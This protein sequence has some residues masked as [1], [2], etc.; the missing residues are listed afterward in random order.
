MASYRQSDDLCWTFLQGLLAFFVNCMTNYIATMESRGKGSLYACYISHFRAAH[1]YILP[2]PPR[3]GW[4]VP[5][6][7]LSSGDPLRL[8]QKATVWTRRGHFSGPLCP[9][10]LLTLNIFPLP[11]CESQGQIALAFLTQ[12]Q[13]VISLLPT[14]VPFPLCVQSW[15]GQETN[16]LGLQHHVEHLHDNGVKDWMWRWLWWDGAT[17]IKQ[18]CE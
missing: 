18:S 5:F 17:W 9:S 1:F 10:S 12:S 14:E 3:T 16:K 4:P 2:F 7:Q 15:R 8:I 11:S 6:T 13:T